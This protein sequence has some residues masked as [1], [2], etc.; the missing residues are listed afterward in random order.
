MSQ[1]L[2]ASDTHLFEVILSHW[3]TSILSRTSYWVI[4]WLQ[5]LIHP[6]HYQS[7]VWRS[8]PVLESRHPSWIAVWPSA[9]HLTSLFIM[10]FSW[11]IGITKI[12][13]PSTW[14]FISIKQVSICKAQHLAHCKPLQHFTY[15]DQLE[16]IYQLYIK[17]NYFQS[18]FSKDY[19]NFYNPSTIEIISNVLVWEV[20][21]AT[22]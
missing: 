7:R 16:E 1:R 5:V 2:T 15:Y 9:H 19:F 17:Q 13:I 14:S 6:R 20:I 21:H 22:Y 11:K 12:T 18:I 4:V 10:F 3:V 8:L